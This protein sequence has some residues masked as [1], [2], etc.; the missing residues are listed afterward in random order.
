MPRCLDDLL[1]KYKVYMLEFF[2]EDL[3]GVYLTGSIVFGEFYEGKSDIDCTVILKSPLDINKLYIVEKIHQEI[4]AQYKN[5]PLE[6]QYIT[7]DDIGKNETTA[8]PC[9]AYHDN[10]LSLGNYANEVTWYTLKKYSI[11]ITGVPADTLDISTSILDVK[12]YVKNNVN[13][14]W[15]YWLNAARAPFSPKRICALTNWAIEW[16]VCGITRMYYTMMEGDITSKGK[17]VE[18]GLICL[19]ESTHKILKEAL[20]IRNGGKTKLYDSRYIRRKDM[21]GYMDYLI[22]VIQSIPV[23]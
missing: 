22:E 11:T 9:Y 2:K 17:A 14:Y 18:Y 15:R 4:S 20:R 5:I 13:S 8:Q 21:I 23:L 10:K 7:L 6:S 12:S 16:C 3:I 19:P 1:S